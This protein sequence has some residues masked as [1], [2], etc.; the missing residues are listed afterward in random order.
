MSSPSA[1]PDEALP[2]TVADRCRRAVRTYAESCRAGVA[3][4]PEVHADELA[5]VVRA[6]A[7]ETFADLRRRLTPPVATHE[8]GPRTPP[9]ASPTRTADGTGE[10]APGDGATA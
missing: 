5:G 6:L 9:P 7:Q 4:R 2:A 3:P 8:S 10:F 1:L